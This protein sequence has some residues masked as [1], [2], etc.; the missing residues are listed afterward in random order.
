MSVKALKRMTQTSCGDEGATAGKRLSVSSSYLL[1]RADEERID[2]EMDKY[3]SVT[4][5]AH[6]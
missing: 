5:C 3:K 2:M 1:D 6:V 4:D